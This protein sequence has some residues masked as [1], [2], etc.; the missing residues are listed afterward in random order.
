MQ[1]INQPI[2]ATEMGQ[3]F[4]EIITKQRANR[5]NAVD[6]F[7]NFWGEVFGDAFQDFGKNL[8]IEM[9]LATLNHE[10]EG[11][12]LEGARPMM[13]PVSIDP[14]LVAFGSG[15]PVKEEAKAATYKRFELPK[16]TIKSALDKFTL[17]QLAQYQEKQ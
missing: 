3:K 15:Q 9:H 11:A 17:Y 10:F 6:E 5:E 1:T 8:K 14:V 2:R 13:M 12:R 7:V 4:S 16:P